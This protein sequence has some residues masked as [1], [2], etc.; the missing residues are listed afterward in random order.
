MRHEPICIAAA[1]LLLGACS[2]STIPEETFPSSSEVRTFY[3]LTPGSCTVFN[4]PAINSV[5]TLEVKGPNTISVAGETLYDQEL[6]LQSS[7]RVFQRQ[8][9]ADERGEV[10]LVRSATGRGS[11]QITT[12]YESVASPVFLRLV[13]DR[14]EVVELTPGARFEVET[15]PERC[16]QMINNGESCESGVAERHVWQVFEEMTSIDTPDGPMDAF[17]LL[18]RRTIGTE[19]DEARYQIVPGR[20]IVG[21]TDFDNNIYNI[22]AWKTCDDSGACNVETPCAEL[23]CAS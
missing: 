2:G 8:F 7:A 5:A 1:A 21:F 17:Q 23:Q 6:T 12:R 11:E 20:G 22:C 9:S 15:T 10:R 3:G 14:N 13:Y 4:V 19:T 18:Y 16:G